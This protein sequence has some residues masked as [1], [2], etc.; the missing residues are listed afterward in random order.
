MSDPPS[1]DGAGRVRVALDTLDEARRGLAIWLGLVL[2][3][4]AGCF[5]LSE[6][7]LESMIPL[8][9]KKLVA[10]DPS[11]PFLTMASL[12][13]YAGLVLSLPAGVYLVWRGV[14]ARWFPQWRRMGGLVVLA[15]TLLFAAGVALCWRVLLP[16]GI[17]FLVGFESEGTSAFISARTFVS[18]VGKM[19][20]ALGLAFEMPLV[21]FF[22]ARAGWL[23]TAFFKK[24]WRHAMLV[25]TVL[26]AVIT[27]TPDVYNMA[28]MTA[29]LLALYFVSFGVVALSF[30][31]P[32]STATDPRS[33]AGPPPRGGPSS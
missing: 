20:L 2:L 12:S 24:R 6:R 1:G 26:A 25:C 4:T 33:S 28:L 27:P 32:G 15:A 10:Y 7:L 11:E 5:H 23:S 31:A 21:A 3:L 22:L 8:L 17:R 29:P 19:L 30:K 13:C 14:S 18:F 16:A 9:G